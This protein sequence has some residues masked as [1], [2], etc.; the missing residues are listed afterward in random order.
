MA[1]AGGLTFIGATRDRRF[2]AFE[3]RTG[4]ELWSVAFDYNVEA[5]PMT[6]EGRD[7]KQ[8]VAVNVSAGGTDETRGNER[9][10]VFSLPND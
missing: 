1:T 10:V 8:Y 9:L 6:Y 7:G 3:S 2:R 4:T 5:I